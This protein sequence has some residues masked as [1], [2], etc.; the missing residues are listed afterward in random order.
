M[1]AA[2]VSD[3]WTRM[4]SRVQLRNENTY[5]Y[6]HAKIRLCDDLHLPFEDVKN[7]VLLGL[8]SKELCN[9]VASKVQYDVDKLLADIR[10]FE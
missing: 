9:N 1:C 5:A 2:S 8:W 6:F 7:Q 3:K 10:L 4:T